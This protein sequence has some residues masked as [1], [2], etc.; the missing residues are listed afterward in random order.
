MRK[1]HL[2]CVQVRCDSGVEEGSEISIYYDPMICKVSFS[3]LMHFHYML[4][5][6][7]KLSLM[8]QNGINT[9]HVHYSKLFH[10]SEFKTFIKI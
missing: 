7:L 5:Q 4:K 6:C 9:N 10:N 1:Y 8:L 3:F 2:C